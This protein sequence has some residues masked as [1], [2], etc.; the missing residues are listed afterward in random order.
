MSENAVSLHDLMIEYV[1]S[2]VEATTP[3]AIIQPLAL[4]KTAKYVQAWMGVDVADVIDER[5]TIFTVYSAY[6]FDL[7]N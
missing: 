2:V 3:D 1:K 6:E 5:D 4:V 7:Y